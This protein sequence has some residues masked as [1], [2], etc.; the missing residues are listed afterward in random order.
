MIAQPEPQ[1]AHNK[2]RGRPAY[3]EDAAGVRSMQRVL[4]AMQPLL[5]RSSVSGRE[6]TNRGL[7]YGLWALDHYTPRRLGQRTPPPLAPV[8]EL[9]RVRDDA[10]RVVRATLLD[11]A[12][13]AGEL[14]KAQQVKAARDPLATRRAARYPLDQVAIAEEVASRYPRPARSEGEDPIRAAER[15][16]ERLIAEALAWEYTHL[17]SEDFTG[18]KPLP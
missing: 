1:S 5:R 13:E 9:E 16:L 2:S 6:L 18:R 7:A 12:R 8:P 11:R 14:T 17:G 4:A 10:V 3:R 15:H